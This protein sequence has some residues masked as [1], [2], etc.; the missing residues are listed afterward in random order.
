[1]YFYSACVVQV[2]SHTS[3]RSIGL[4]LNRAAGVKV[5]DL[6]VGKDLQCVFG[7]RSLRL[8][9]CMN[10]DSLHIF[11]ADPQIANS[12]EMCPGMYTGGLQS[13]ISLMSAGATDPDKC[14]LICG[15]MHW[16]GGQ[17][18]Q[19]VAK[20]TWLPISAC[21]E[22]VIDISCRDDRCSTAWHEILAMTSEPDRVYQ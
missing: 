7:H 12:H 3:H 4:M 22:L 20:G 13:A 11:H 1:M 14:A 9:G 18:D 15:S 21:P 19:D 16:T 5:E 2:V 17:L 10:H 8:G 6:A